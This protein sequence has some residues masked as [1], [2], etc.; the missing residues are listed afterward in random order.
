MIDKEKQFKR[1]RAWTKQNKERIV[2]DAPKGLRDE[3]KAKAEAE[4]LSLTAWIIKKCQ[5]NKRRDEE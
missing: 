4:G 1:Q 5:E 3:W 2:M